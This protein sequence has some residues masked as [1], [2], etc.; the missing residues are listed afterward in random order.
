M[1][2]RKILDAALIANKVVDELI[3]RKQRVMCKLDMEKA[4][5]NVH[6]RFVDYMLRMMGFGEKWRR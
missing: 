1:G 3:Y 2:V 6:W 4:Y 5:N